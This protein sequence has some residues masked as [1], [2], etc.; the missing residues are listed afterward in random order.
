MTGDA[1]TIFQATWAP[2]GISIPV[3]VGA[4][5]LGTTLSVQTSC[6]APLTT[7]E[8]WTLAAAWTSLSRRTAKSV[9]LNRRL[10]RVRE[11]LRTSA[12]A[13]KTPLTEK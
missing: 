10:G 7:S 9:A 13:A 12:S 5:L 1:E 3:V 2:G 6:V 8:T 11:T 4:Q